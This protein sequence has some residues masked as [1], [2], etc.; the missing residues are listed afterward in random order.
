MASVT[1]PP[2]PSSSGGGIP[3]AGTRDPADSV[4]DDF[5][6]LVAESQQQ[7]LDSARRTGA[8]WWD[9]IVLQFE[10]RRR[11]LSAR[12]RADAEAALP[13]EPV[14]TLA[15]RVIGLQ[16]GTL[17]L[18]RLDG[19]GQRPLAVAGRDETFPLGTVM[20]GTG[21]EAHR[22]AGGRPLRDVAVLVLYDIATTEPLGEEGVRS[23]YRSRQVRAL[24][25]E[26]RA[27][28]PDGDGGDSWWER[29]DYLGEADVRA[30]LSVVGHAHRAGQTG[31]VEQSR[32][33]LEEWRGT[34]PPGQPGLPLQLAELAAVLDGL[35][36]SA[37]KPRFDA[38][39]AGRPPAT[40][41]TFYAGVPAL[42]EPGRRPGLRVL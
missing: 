16:L 14:D 7:G 41:S 6:D 19:V 3:P 35:S 30:L 23:E 24:V 27:R 11:E 25:E 28:T 22:W 34:V 12:N 21:S 10:Q 5:L 31:V 18:G 2:L 13:A 29:S 17:L 32:G 15:A 42:I 9:A 20:V 39:T 8:T 4:D 26:W 1:S 40:A 36:A 37:A 33:L 38:R